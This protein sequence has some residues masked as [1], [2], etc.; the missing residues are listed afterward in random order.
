MTLAVV[1]AAVTVAADLAAVG[2][3][4]CVHELVRLQLVRV[5][6]LGTALAAGEGPLAGVH[7]F[8]PPQVGDLD[9]AFAADVTLEG[10]LAGVQPDVRLEMVVACEPFLA[11]RALV[12]FLSGM[13]A[14]VVLE[15]V[16]VVERFV[17]K[18][19][20]VFLFGIG[21]SVSGGGWRFCRHR[22]TIRRRR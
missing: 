14:A 22:T 16:L 17:A 7:A 2:H 19:A 20:R 9:E 10:F 13:G 21:R 8:V 3:D 12:R 4:I 15:D 5:G 18:V 11:L 6:E 1:L